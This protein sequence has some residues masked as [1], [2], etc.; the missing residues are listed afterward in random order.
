MALCHFVFTQHHP[1]SKELPH[2]LPEFSSK[3]SV[4]HSA[5]A[6]F[7]APS[8][9]SGMSEMYQEHIRANPNYG[10]NLQF[11][12]VFVSVADA[13]SPDLEGVYV[14]RGLLIVRVLLFYS[15]Y[16]PVLQR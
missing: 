7:Y 4:F 10:G 2:I 15:F 11:D 3:I 8:N 16:D 5:V 1:E 13:D 14:M 6:L 12:T 9:L